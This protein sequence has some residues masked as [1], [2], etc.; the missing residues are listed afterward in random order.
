[1]QAGANNE[2]LVESSLIT[3]L[4][5]AASSGSLLSMLQYCMQLLCL[6][7]DEPIASSVWGTALS[8]AHAAQANAVLAAIKVS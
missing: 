6:N 5:L 3:S 4:Q 1:M 7:G 2:A 8:G